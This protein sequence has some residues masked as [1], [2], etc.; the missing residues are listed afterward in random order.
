MAHAPYV[1]HASHAPGARPWAALTAALALCATAQAQNPVDPAPAEL[2]AVTVTGTRERAYRAVIA[3]TA[4]K[5]DTTVKETP[6]SIQ[7]VTR[8]LIEDRGVTTFGE[9]VRTVPGLTP[10]VGWGGSNDRFRLRGF[11]TS[12]NLK[13]GFRRSVFAPVDELVN[14]EQIEVL[15]GPASA[16]Y[17]RFEPGGV[18]NLV[19][20]KPQERART[21]FEL[22]AGSEDFYRATVDSTGPLSDTLSYRLTGAWQDNRSFRDFVD[23][24]TAFVSPV[25]QWKLGAQTRL[26]AELELGRRNAAFDRGFGN[27]PLFLR[28]PIHHN[29]AERD[30]R[31]KNDSALASL[32]LEHRFDSGWDLRAGLQGSHAKTD[33]LWYPYGFTPLSGAQGPDPQVNRRKQRSI[34]AQTDTSV[35]A[36]LSRRFET[37]AVRHR[38]LIG[39]DANRDEWDFT[40][41]A[42][43]GPFGFPTNLPISLYRPVHGTGLNAALQPYDASNYRSR[44]VGLYAQDEL[45]LGEHWRVLL[46][47]RHDRSRSQGRADY[48]PTRET[49][50]RTDSAWSPRVGVTWTPLPAAS[51]YASWSRSFLTEPFSGML[52]NGSLPAPS[53]GTQ[54]EVGTK[55]SL[56]DGRLEPTLAVFDIRRRNGTVS[57]PDDFNYVIQVGEQRSRGWELDVPFS[58]SPQ[59][60]VLASYTHLKAEISQDSDAAMVGKLLANAPR[61]SA[62][63]WSTYDF[64]GAAAGWSAGLGAIHVG[65]RQANTGNTFVLPAYTRWDANLAWRFGPAQRYKLQLTV[66]NLGDKRYY[67]S[68][69][70][71]VPTYPGAPRSV[72]ATFGMTL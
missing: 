36:E 8:E 56:L 1:P 65:A 30:A 68:G 10:Q 12:A 16:L 51:V 38:V 6:F 67:D 14:I 50:S 4:N 57:D 24:R 54:V 55:L 21:S 52:R 48:L 45:Q 64:G 27:S 37:G 53:R 49:L 31:L 66:Q 18:V 43:I 39:A 62:S 40:A 20:K 19:T 59:W 5:S 47:L 33:A 44:S 11:A 26:S 60:R 3:P 71:F 46:G 17:G 34:D 29:Y 61:R 7:T 41:D 69:G 9:A 42:N 22:T 13:N 28:V 2:E 58:I 25:F 15:K 70:A 63:L 23:A 72:M 35:M 32:V